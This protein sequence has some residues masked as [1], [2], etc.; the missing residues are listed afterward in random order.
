MLWLRRTGAV[1][2]AVIFVITALLVMVAFR[3]TATAGNPDFYTEQLQRADVY[4]LVYDDV[5]PAALEEYDIT[6]DAG[7]LGA[8]FTPLQ[9]HLVDLVRQTLPPGGNKEPFA[10]R[11]YF[12]AAL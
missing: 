5:L 6:E 10:P 1:I 3:V 2:L 8:V 4:N 9:P 7:G 11:G 12:I